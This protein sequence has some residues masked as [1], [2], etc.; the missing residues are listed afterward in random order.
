[1]R[2]NLSPTTQANLCPQIDYKIQVDNPFIH[3]SSLGTVE[4]MLQPAT[5]GEELRNSDRHSF[6]LPP[7]HTHSCLTRG[8]VIDIIFLH[9]HARREM[10]KSAVRIVL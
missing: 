1:M 8:M 9:S 4:V 7:Y 6:L 2:L 5:P 3:K 10:K